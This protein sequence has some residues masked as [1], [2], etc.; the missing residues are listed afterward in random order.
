MT[1][2]D[3]TAA[4]AISAMQRG[5][6]TVSF[7]IDALL[8]QIKA[9]KDLNAFICLDET[10]LR[11]A[12]HDL[13]LRRAAGEKCGRLFGLPMVVKDN[14]ETS[15]FPTTG[16]SPGLKHHRPDRNAPLLQKLLGEGALVLGKANMH[17][18]AFGITSNNAAFSPVRNPYNSDMIAGGSS[19]GSAAAVAAHMAPFALGTD[20]GGSTRIPP[21]LCGI[22]GYRPTM[23]RYG[24]EGVI[25][26][27]HT[28][29]TLG[30]MARTVED[31]LLIDGIVR[32]DLLPAEE[33]PLKSLT[34]IRLGI[35]RRYFFQDLDLAVQTAA[36][37]ALDTLRALGAE[38]VEVDIPNL[39]GLNDA[40]SLPICLTEAVQDMTDYLE[41]TGISF[42][43][44]VEAIAS[45]DVQG[46]YQ[47]ITA[48]PPCTS[49]DYHALLTHDRPALQDAYRRYFKEH[50]LDAMVFPTTKLP[51]RP[52]G[53]DDEVQINGLKSP[54]FPSYI[55]NTDPSSNAGLP[56]ISV[57]MAMTPTGL[58]LGLEFDGPEDSDRHLM[59]I[60][61]VFF[62][63]IGPLPT[64]PTIR[65]DLL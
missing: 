35:S 8:K 20:T 21:A 39:A 24:A 1:V 62:T 53:E 44:M 18:L 31:I 34:G 55:H 38:L 16:G 54:T 3:L 15:D 51:A 33:T 56:G 19:G 10:H 2:L 11:D 13:D 27:S 25:P 42:D 30:T 63:E 48:A 9:H 17:E 50:Q 45:P 23:G 12:A 29:D 26:V 49:E 36:E 46:L 57:P 60:A 64:P 5:K 37:H 59:R 32:P 7:Y 61:E 43:Q 52:I 47:N 58:P 6:I 14:I 65:K 41:N 40:V 22:V 4:E 28:R